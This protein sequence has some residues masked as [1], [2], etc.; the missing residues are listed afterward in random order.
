MSFTYARVTDDIQ[1]RL[2]LT[3]LLNLVAKSLG[4]TAGTGLVRKHLG[5]LVHRPKHVAHFQLN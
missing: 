5:Q 3:K 4:D 1:Q 2:M